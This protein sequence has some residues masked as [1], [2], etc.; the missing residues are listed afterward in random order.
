LKKTVVTF[1]GSA[2]S[3]R[4]F[5][6]DGL[7]EIAFLGRSNVGKSSLL[8]ALAGI[9]LARVSS[10]PG[11][12]RL[13][14]F[15]RYGNEL[16]LTDLPGYGFARVGADLQRN[17]EALVRAYLEG[18]EAL[19]LCVMLLDIRRDIEERELLLRQY[20]EEQG[21]PYVLVATKIDTLK[22]HEV[23]VRREAIGEARLAPVMTVSSKTG[24]GLR[25]LWATI[26]EAARRPG[27]GEEDNGS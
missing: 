8:N 16:Y 3:P 4:Q 9:D 23:P 7:P 25:Q 10:D 15:F 6:K 21:I 19:A 12:T 22:K 13:V 18:R 24:V 27:G 20:L 2:A 14:N 17:W 5:P 1:A 11:R 26:R